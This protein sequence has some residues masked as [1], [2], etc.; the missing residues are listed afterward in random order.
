MPLVFHFNSTYDLL[1][2]KNEHG[3]LAEIIINRIISEQKIDVD[4]VTGA[5][6]SSKVIEGAIQNA[7]NKT[8]LKT[9]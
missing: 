4:A 5:T 3:K 8:S 7:L 9:Y 1:E 6:N 2:H